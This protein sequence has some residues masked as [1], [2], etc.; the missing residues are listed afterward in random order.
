[1]GPIGCPETSARSY[2]YSLRNNPKERG[3]QV[4]FY[5]EKLLKYSDALF[6]HDSVGTLN[7]VMCVTRTE[8]E[9]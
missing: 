1:M 3:F 8:F 9:R 7:Q 4:A 6:V 5:F 2:Q